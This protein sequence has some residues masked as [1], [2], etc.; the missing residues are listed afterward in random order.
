MKRIIVVCFSL[1]MSGMFLCALFAQDKNEKEKEEK[2][3][4][5]I[6]VLEEKK[7]LLELHTKYTSLKI[8]FLEKK[9]QCAELDQKAKSLEKL[10]DKA[11]ED[12]QG[13]NSKET[14]K[15]LAKSKRANKKLSRVKKQMR[16]L[17]DD[18]RSIERKI[19][20][21]NYLLEIKEK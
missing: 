16:D 3:F 11:A 18:I 12:Y 17:E 10:A 14:R 1:V 20:L 19:T 9:Q 13:V 5:S 2:K 4:D 6:S 21:Q 15:T 7:D 8:K